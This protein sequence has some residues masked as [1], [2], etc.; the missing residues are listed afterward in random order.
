MAANHLVT[1]S[2][3]SVIP[4]GS[5]YRNGRKREKSKKKSLKYY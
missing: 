3:K 4:P 2:V 1:E 5:K